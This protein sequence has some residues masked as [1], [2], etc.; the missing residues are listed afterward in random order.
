MKILYTAEATATGGRQGRV[1]SSDGAVSLDLV[2]PKELGGPGGTATNPEQLFAAGFAACYDNAV[3]LVAR[4]N[5]MRL[6]E[7]SVTARVGIGPND[8]GG[9]NLAVELHV[10][11]PD[12]DRDQA[13]QLARQAHQICPYSNATRGNIDVQI[14]VEPASDLV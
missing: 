2:I 3:R 8:S 5:K 11:L 1:W 10:R 13:E 12:L 4:R 14:I 7:S 6:V 9:Y